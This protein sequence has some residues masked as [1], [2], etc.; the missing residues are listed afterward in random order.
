M[1]VVLFRCVD[2][3]INPPHP[4]SVGSMAVCH[5]HYQNGKFLSV[6]EVSTHSGSYVVDLLN[7]A[8]RRRS[9]VLTKWKHKY[10][11]WNFNCYYIGRYHNLKVS[12]RIVLIF[13]AWSLRFRGIS[14]RTSRMRSQKRKDAFQ[15][16]NGKLNPEVL[17][18]ITQTGQ[19]S[20]TAHFSDQKISNKWSKKASWKRTLINAHYFRKHL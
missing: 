20:K 17:L 9:R 8:G 18:T 3:A 2:V 16:P 19:F 13:I 10:W 5:Y 7:L 4:H 6:R 14:T 1:G 15:R 12:Y 11:F